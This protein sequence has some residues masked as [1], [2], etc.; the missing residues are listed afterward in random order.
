VSDA[1]AAFHADLAAHG[2]GRRVVTVVHS[3]FGR[4]APEN[5]SLGTDHGLGSVMFVIGEAVRG[6]IY[7]GYP[8]L[9]RLVLDGN[10]EVTTDFR[11]VFSTILDRHLD[12]D[13]QRVL[14]GPFPLLGF[15]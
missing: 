1:L 4:R 12:A 14:G 10:L 3:E 11:S 8:R 6:G 7:G 13:P 5:I 15:L 9:D 2:I